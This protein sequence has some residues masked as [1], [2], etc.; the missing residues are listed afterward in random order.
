[1]SETLL[2]GTNRF[3]CDGEVFGR[4][5]PEA[6]RVPDSSMYFAKQKPASVCR[7]DGANE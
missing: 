5:A 3:T 1:M 7:N 4:G 6:E 2:L